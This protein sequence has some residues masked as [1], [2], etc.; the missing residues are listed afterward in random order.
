MNTITLDLND[1]NCA[2]DLWLSGCELVQ[3][4]SILYKALVPSTG[5][6]STTA[7]E[8]LR[9]ANRTAYRFLNDGDTC[10]KW[11]AD[12]VGCMSDREQ[13]AYFWHYIYKAVKKAAASRVGKQALAAAGVEVIF[14]L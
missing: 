10:P 2:Q 8:T 6:A 1:I 4:N 11:H 14:S 7:G 13:I 9:K 3:V 5:A 12:G